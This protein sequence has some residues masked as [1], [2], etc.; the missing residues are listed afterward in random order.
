MATR[1][2]HEQAIVR[3]F[4]PAEIEPKGPTPIQQRLLEAAARQNDEERSFLYQHSVFCQTSLPF[5][6]PGAGVR[7]WERT[8]GNVSLLVEAGR[9]MAPD[10]RW[11]ELQLPAGVKARLV[12]MYLNQRAM[13]TKSPVLE[14]GSLTDFTRRVLKLDP[15]GRNLTA[16]KEQLARLSA[17]DFLFGAVRDGEAVTI[18]AAP[19]KGFNLWATK[20]DDEQRLLW[21]RIVELDPVYFAD[22]ME[23]AVPLD[24]RHIAALTHSCMALDIYS[25]LAQRL[26]RLKGKQHVSWPALWSQFGQGYNPERMDKFRQVFRLALKQVLAVYQAARVEDVEAGKPRLVILG[27][28]QRLWR[29]ETATG[30]WLRP[31][32]PPVKRKL[33]P[34]S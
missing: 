11:I 28:E 31:S 7:T 32:P 17:A 18:K 21:P 10:R 30:L 23:H 25:W 1:K 24:E 8:N 29:S 26:H 6:D 9:A 5:R 2:E 14:V 20:N 4:Q 13:L 3:L 19:V 15:K 22:L 27:D 33:L 12:L 16:V 34:G